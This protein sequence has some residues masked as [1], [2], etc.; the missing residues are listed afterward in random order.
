VH[1]VG[2]VVDQPY[3]VIDSHVL[4]TID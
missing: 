1:D 3:L 4:T 2:I